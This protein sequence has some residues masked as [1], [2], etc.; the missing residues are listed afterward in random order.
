MSDTRGPGAVEATE[1]AL[2]NVK[3]WNVDTKALITV[4]D[5]DALSTAKDIDARQSR[6][7]WCGLLAGMTMSIKDNVDVAGVLTTA[8]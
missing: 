2:A 6:G 8:G 3:I 7:E 5:T 1:Q 4:T